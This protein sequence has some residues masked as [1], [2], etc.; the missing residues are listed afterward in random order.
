RG[1]GFSG[2]VTVGVEGVPAEID[3]TSHV[4]TPERTRL[5]IH[6]RSVMAARAMT[7]VGTS[8][9]ASPR[10]VV[11]VA[12]DPLPGSLDP[13]FGDGGLVPLFGVSA[14][15]QAGFDTKGRIVAIDSPMGI[16]RYLP[17]GGPDTTFGDGG[18]APL[19]PKTLV[20]LL[21]EPSFDDATRI[22]LASSA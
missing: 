16:V 13:A 14:F 15:T 12:V 18:A 1:G 2:D 7:I 8:G 11:T 9:N 20:G 3:V 17:D 5:D 22:T 6:G 4:E 21:G 10:A 19:E